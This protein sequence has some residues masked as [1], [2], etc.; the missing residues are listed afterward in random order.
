MKKLLFTTAF[1]CAVSMPLAAPR[2]AQAQPNDPVAATAA[3][4]ASFT[5][6][7]Y[8]TFNSWTGTTSTFTVSADGSYTLDNGLGSKFSGKL[9]PA[10]LSAL[11]SGLTK[12]DLKGN[13]GKQVGGMVPDD[14]SFQIRETE[15]GKTYKISGFVDSANLGVVKSLVSSLQD[16]VNKAQPPAAHPIDSGADKT[17]LPEEVDFSLRHQIK[18]HWRDV[19]IKAD[20]TVTV[21]SYAGST[22]VKEVKHTYTSKLTPN[23]AAS[24]IAALKKSD[25]S[26]LPAEIPVAAHSFGD[27]RFSIATKDGGKSHATGGW[28]DEYDPKYKK[29]TDLVH[30]LEGITARVPANENPPVN[31]DPSKPAKDDFKGLELDVENGM[32]L[33]KSK[34]TIDKDG[35]YT[36]DPPHGR[37]E[38][39]G[40]LTAQE[41]DA[42]KAS[43]NGSG[44]DT[45]K[46][47]GGMI[48]DGAMFTLKADGKTISGFEAGY[49]AAGAD[50]QVWAKLRPLLDNL[51]AV[52]TSVD[53]GKPFVA[54]AKADATESTGKGVVASILGPIN[55]WFK[56]LK[57]VNAENDAMSKIDA[58]G[59]PSRTAGMSGLLTDRVAGSADK[60]KDGADSAGER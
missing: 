35:N 48:P 15:G 47:P 1:A 46:S 58:N 2:L 45:L 16:A 23:E 24:L 27:D 32:A 19:T 9:S 42:V 14:T 50:A 33:Y 4:K 56:K 8:Q 13:D 21:L 52:Q 55:D 28:V 40:K 26:K 3:S 7:R 51:D 10:Q 39:K 25:F 18:D 44:F 59:R 30:A 37:P 11:R 5:S 43:F 20:G 6:I 57:G 31:P 49:M 60:S 41:L 34:L 38:V 54:P 17:K 22:Q 12:A 29:I 36:Y 53:T